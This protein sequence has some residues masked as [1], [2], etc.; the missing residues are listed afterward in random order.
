MINFEDPMNPSIEVRT[1]Q[2][3]EYEGREITRDEVF[4]L[5]Y[6]TVK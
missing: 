1:W 5:D 2:P 3:N 6:F 4:N